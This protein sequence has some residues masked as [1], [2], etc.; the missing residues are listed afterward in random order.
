MKNQFVKIKPKYFKRDAVWVNINH[1]VRID[2]YVKG[3]TTITLACPDIDYSGSEDE[4]DDSNLTIFTI[5]CAPEDFI[6]MLGEK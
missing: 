5:E 2:E 1:I 3:E 4:E 6:K